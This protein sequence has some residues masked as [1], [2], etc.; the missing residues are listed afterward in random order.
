MQL[1]R[2]PARSLSVEVPRDRGRLLVL[3]GGVLGALLV[4]M[5]IV[6]L[7]PVHTLLSFGRSAPTHV[8]TA[9]PTPVERTLFAEPLT[10]TSDRNWPNTDQCSQRA[11][12]YHIS[13]NV[14]CLL[15]PERYTPPPD[16]NISVDVKQVSGLTD[17]SYGITF[18]RVSQG[19]FYTFEIN[20][21]GLWFFFRAQ[22]GQIKLLAGSTPQRAIHKGLNATNTLSVRITGAHY[23]FFVNSQPVG[24]ADDSALGSGPAGLDGNDQIEVVY[25]NFKVTKTVG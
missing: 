21:S 12:G 9:T 23:A 5:L 16:V 17:V 6:L 19:S 14:V 13:A 20:S 4:V 10:S 18:H 7:S 1:E 11:D 22:N 3:G 25:T 8:P 2:M 24:A 15:T